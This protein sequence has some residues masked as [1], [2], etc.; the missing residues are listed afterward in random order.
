MKKYYQKSPLLIKQYNKIQD[1]LNITFRLL[2]MLKKSFIHWLWS[3][4][5]LV[6]GSKP[7]NSPV[8]IH[9]CSLCWSE[10]NKPIC[11]KSFQDL[12]LSFSGNNILTFLFKFVWLNM[13]FLFLFLLI[14]CT[15]ICF[16]K[17]NKI[18][19]Q[20]WIILRKFDFLL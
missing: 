2:V 15:S 16:S 18:Y 19:I 10:I 1:S 7:R 17:I 9:K 4:I 12:I 3:E 6:N 8:I 11:C 14:N 5:I 13:I 20:Y